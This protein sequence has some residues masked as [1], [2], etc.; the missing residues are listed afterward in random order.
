SVIA[1][2]DFME[3]HPE[4]V[5]KLHDNVA[6]FVNSLR[7]I[8]FAIEAPTAIVPIALP[9]AVE[10]M[11]VVAALHREGVFVNGVE[12]PAVPRDK[13]R[14]RVSMMATLTR[15]QLDIAVEKITAVAHR[16]GFHPNQVGT[17]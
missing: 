9:A 4:R 2:I 1:G 3:A 16:F 5:A 8:G 6:Y 17:S 10:V 13:Q 11:E 12:F 14:I 15:A 7:H